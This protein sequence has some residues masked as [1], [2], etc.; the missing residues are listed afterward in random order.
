MEGVWKLKLMFFVMVITHELLHLLV[1][2]IKYSI[3]KDRGHNNK[4][5]VNRYFLGEAF[6]YGDDTKCWG[7]VDIYSQPL[8]LEF[9]SFV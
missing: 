3:V 2:Q 1:R 4:F 9:C 7:Y 6:K 5:Y 8:C